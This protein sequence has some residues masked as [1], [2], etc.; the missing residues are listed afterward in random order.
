MS[1]VPPPPAP[2]SPPSPI[3]SEPAPLVIVAAQ[4]SKIAVVGTNI[5]AFTVSILGVSGNATSPVPYTYNQSPQEVQV[6]VG[7]NAALFVND[8]LI[9]SPV[10]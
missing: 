4:I 9:K 2:P 3:S 5:G 10:T 7:P 6:G 1:Y 8:P